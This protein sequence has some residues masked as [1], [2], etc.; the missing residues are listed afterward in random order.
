MN[1]EVNGQRQAVHGD[2]TVADLLTQHDL[3]A[4]RVAV[5][6]NATLVPRARFGDTPISDGDRIEIVTLVGGG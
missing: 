4:A 5:E 6:V 2:A 1:I 3:V